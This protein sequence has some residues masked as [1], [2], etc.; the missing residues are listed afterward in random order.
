M[1]ELIKELND[2]YMKRVKR[3]NLKKKK[4]TPITKTEKEEK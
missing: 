4:N 2:I 1:A 3:D